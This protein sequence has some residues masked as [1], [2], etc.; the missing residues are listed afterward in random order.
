PALYKSIAAKA[1]SGMLPIRMS[2]GTAFLG[3]SLLTRKVPAVRIAK[4]NKIKIASITPAILRSL[5]L[6]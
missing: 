6:V 1:L 3:C 2:A 5:H 4:N